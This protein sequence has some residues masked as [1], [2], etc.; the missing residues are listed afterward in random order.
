[1]FGTDAI[2]SRMPLNNFAVFDFLIFRTIGWI[3]MMRSLSFSMF[4]TVINALL[5]LRIVLH[6][7]QDRF[8]FDVVVFI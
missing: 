4:L 1:M 2:I 6:E 5:V 8:F 7:L 3:L